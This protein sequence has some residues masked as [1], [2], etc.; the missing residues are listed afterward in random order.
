M[1]VPGP[2][3]A[4]LAADASTCVQLIC[5]ITQDGLA[6]ERAFGPVQGNLC[7]RVESLNSS[8]TRE[9]NGFFV[10]VLKLWSRIEDFQSGRHGHVAFAVSAYDLAGQGKLEC[11]MAKRKVLVSQGLSKI[12]WRDSQVQP[13]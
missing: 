5:S 12:G 8:A 9:I 10:K 11:Q 13:E 3:F 7:A 6:V 4:P 2:A 1:S